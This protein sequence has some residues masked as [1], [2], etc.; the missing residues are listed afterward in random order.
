MN[1]VVIASKLVSTLTSFPKNATAFELNSLDDLEA[2]DPS[3][4]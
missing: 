2:I 1:G 3:I 4:Y